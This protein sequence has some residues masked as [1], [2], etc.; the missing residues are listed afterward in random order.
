MEL[1]LELFWSNILLEILLEILLLLEFLGCYCHESGPTGEICPKCG[2][3]FQYL[4]LAPDN[5]TQWE[6]KMSNDAY[7][8]SL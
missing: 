5:R 3:A 1:Y 7:K 2:E 8:V 6:I 4:I